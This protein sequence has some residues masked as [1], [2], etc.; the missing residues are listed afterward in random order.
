M[1]QEKVFKLSSSKSLRISLENVKRGT[2]GLNERRNRILNRVPET[3]VVEEN[4][5][6][7]S[8][9]GDVNM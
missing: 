8:E 7:G 9:F 5:A 2:S 6:G 3:C 4:I 1:I